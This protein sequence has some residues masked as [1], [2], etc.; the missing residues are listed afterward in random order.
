VARGS[1]SCA[2]STVATSATLKTWAPSHGPR[3][4]FFKVKVLLVH[5]IDTVKQNF[6]V[7]LSVKFQWMLSEAEKAAWMLSKNKK[8]SFKA[9]WKPPKVEIESAVSLD[10]IDSDD[11]EVHAF[12][13][14]LVGHS[15][16]VVKGTFVEVMALQ[17]FPFDCQ[18]LDLC[19]VFPVK[20]NGEFELHP[21]IDRPECVRM[22]QDVKLLPEYAFVNPIVELTTTDIAE[23]H[24]DF[25]YTT[26]K[27][28]TIVLHLKAK[29]NWRGHLN[30]IV[31]TMSLVSLAVLFAFMIPHTELSD[32]LA[33]ATTLFLTAVAFQLVVSA[34][35]PTVDYLTLIDHYIIKVNMYILASMFLMSCTF[36]AEHRELLPA[37]QVETMDFGCM[38]VTACMWA[39]MHAWLGAKAMYA[40]KFVEWP[41]LR[42][43]GAQP[44]LP[45]ERV[46]N[47]QFAIVQEEGRRIY[48]GDVESYKFLSGITV[49]VTVW[50]GL[51]YSEDF[52]VGHG[53]EYVFLSIM[54]DKG[55]PQLAARKITGDENVP[56]GRITWM[57][58]SGP[59]T[60]GGPGTP[61]QVQVRSDTSNTNGFSWMDIG[62]LEAV[63]LDEIRIRHG[64]FRRQL[65]RPEIETPKPASVATNETTPLLSPG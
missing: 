54:N 41:K 51:W 4:V 6:T 25:T 64:T 44:K 17:N 29:R 56:C 2:M 40:L 34:N 1:C 38:M 36:Y 65:R 45:E 47:M 60:V 16:Q 27:H 52:Y 18:N 15:K 53:I 57:T 37:D 7:A 32:R 11:V 24:D 48:V 55:V 62:D 46:A 33:H 23:L 3:Q 14:M 21:A 12:A 35:L 20:D 8:T 50:A 19:M 43:C 10:V 26:T 42:E 58:K 13:N 61:V 63:S 59:P 31:V 5:E 39:S 22:T 9:D 30:K 49:D 28:P